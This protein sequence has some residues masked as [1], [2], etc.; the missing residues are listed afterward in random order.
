[1]DDARVDPPDVDQ[2]VGIDGTHGVRA[3]VKLRKPIAP[4]RLAAHCARLLS[5]H[6]VPR[7]VKVVKRLD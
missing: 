6:K 4:D 5:P 3:R 1:V 2:P 7:D